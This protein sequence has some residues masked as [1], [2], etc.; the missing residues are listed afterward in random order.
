MNFF[1]SV[2]SD[3]PDPDSKSDSESQPENVSDP[4]SDESPDPNTNQIGGWS[5]GG[6][7][8]TLSE[9]SE[10]VIETYRRDLMEFG[11]G[12]KKEI[13]VAHESIE[14]VSHKIDEIGTSVIK[15]TTQIINQGKDAILVGIDNQDSDSSEDRSYNNNN[16]QQQRGGFISEQ[17]YSRFDSQV[18]AIQG[19]VN[20]Y[21]EEPEDLEEYEKWRESFVLKSEEIDRLKEENGVID[22]VYKRVVPS[23]VDGDVFWSRYFYKVYKLKLA[24]EVRASLVKRAI[25]TEE[26]ELSWDV[27][28]DDEEEVE[29][30][31]IVP[32]KGKDNVIEEKSV[33]GDSTKFVKDEGPSQVE[34]SGFSSEVGD[35]VSDKELLKGETLET[36]E[37]S[38]KDSLA[39]EKEENLTKTSA[40]DLEKVEKT[41]E[42]SN[43]PSVSKSDE[44]PTLED[45]HDNGSSTKSSDISIIS[46]QPP[47]PDEEEDLGWDE[48]E[49]LSSIEEKTERKTTPDGGSPNRA[50]LRKRLSV[51]EEDE[52]LNWDIEDDDD[53]PINKA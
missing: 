5:F 46:S 36:R 22:S 31:T 35:K 42:K 19:D 41:I 44:K 10:S 38:E 25:S 52:E 43:E 48:I 40:D 15:N 49:D 37:L 51:A 32:A 2:F 7:I 18:R 1:K 12:L 24:E 20:T 50:D 11:D 34:G 23:V 27:D 26:E 33:S 47:M 13:E 53:E 9:R 8:K 21:C 6:L 45:K 30:E 14:T 29:Y 17:R 3:E 39:G 4:D 16:N 28:D